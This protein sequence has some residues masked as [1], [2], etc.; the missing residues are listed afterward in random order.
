ME[1]G[2]TVLIELYHCCSVHW[3]DE[4][5]FFLGYSGFIIS[6]LDADHRLILRCAF[7]FPATYCTIMFIHCST[8][9]LQFL[10]PRAPLLLPRSI[11]LACFGTFIAL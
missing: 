9:C 6:L 5:F 10:I 11:K 3:S 4:E 7:C 8:Q 2:L 1:L